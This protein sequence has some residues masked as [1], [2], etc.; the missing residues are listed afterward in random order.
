[1]ELLR[2]L[3]LSFMDLEISFAFS[4]LYSIGKK[5]YKWLVNDFENNIITLSPLSGNPTKWSNTQTI[6]RQT[7][8]ELFECDWPF[9]GIGA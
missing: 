4:F 3:F 2:R 7:A 1:M 6:R 8:D 5:I 9:C